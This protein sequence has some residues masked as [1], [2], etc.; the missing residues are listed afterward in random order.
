MGL[1]N[2]KGNIVLKIL[3]VAALVLLFLSI[4]IPR[5]MWNE[6][7]ERAELAQERMDVMYNMELLYKQETDKFNGSLKEVYDF[8]VG[9][10]SLEVN[11]PS[12]QTEYLTI[13]STQLRIDYEQPELVEN[14]FVSYEK[15]GSMVEKLDKDSL[16]KSQTAFKGSNELFVT[17]DMRDKELGLVPATLHLTSET[18]I[19]II[20]NVKTATDIYW[21]FYGDSKIS[22]E[23]IKPENEIQFVNLARYIMPD[24]GDKTPYLCPSTLDEFLVN[25]NLN[26]KVNMNIEFTRGTELDTTVLKGVEI[27]PVTSNDNI[28]NFMIDK[29]GQKSLNSVADF[30]REHEVDGD[31]TYSN[32]KAQDSL[33]IAFFNKKLKEFAKKP[34]TDKDSKNLKSIDIEREANFGKDRQ[35]ALFFT[36]RVPAKLVDEINKPEVLEQLALINYGMKTEIIDVDTLSVKISSPINDKSE[37]KGYERSALRSES[38]FGVEDDENHGYIDD[39]EKSWSKGGE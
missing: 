27:A 2:R 9:Y 23:L 18:P 21:D 8:A 16:K 19:K 28:K 15:G 35:F 29:L 13:D 12:F 37:F 25:F 30:V 6:K 5:Q 38:L 33:F 11:P 31:S 1:I 3:I 20:S 17:L 39:G 4:D 22:F 34:Y 7:H 32:E 14:L 36:S 10:D 24:I 26:A